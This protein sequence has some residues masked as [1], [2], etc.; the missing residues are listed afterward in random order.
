MPPDPSHPPHPD[1]ARSRFAVLVLAAPLVLGLLVR[2]R[3]T[4]ATL[5]GLEG[6][7]CVVGGWCGPAGCPGCGLTRSTALT[8]QG[9]LGPALALNWA[10]PLLVLACLGGLA[11]HLDIL[12]RTCRR[13]RA[14]ERILRL[15]T[16]GLA[17]AVLLSWAA[18]L[19]PG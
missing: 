7:T 9:D 18:R 16:V 12:L 11:L 19:L 14:H 4:Q 6:P 8:V 15:G 5:F 17:L 1:L 3:G 13:T 2:V 10:G